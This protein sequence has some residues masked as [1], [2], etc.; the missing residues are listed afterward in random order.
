MAAQ[1]SYSNILKSACS[2]DLSESNFYL[3]FTA[4]DKLMVKAIDKKG[5]YE[6]GFS[7]CMKK[8]L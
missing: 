3:A 4:A 5:I 8:L 7:T 2:L 1:I 6:L